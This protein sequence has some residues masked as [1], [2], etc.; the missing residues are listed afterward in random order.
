MLRISTMVSALV[1]LIV[2]LNCD[3]FA[4]EA[5]KPKKPGLAQSLT[6]LQSNDT[7]RHAAATRALVEHGRN[8]HKL[9]SP[10]RKSK[11]PALAKRA[12][13]VCQ[14]IEMRAKQ[15][16]IM[17]RKLNFNLTRANLSVENLQKVQQAFREM[18][19]YTPYPGLRNNAETYIR[20]LDQ[21][22]KVVRAATDA[23]AK[24]DSRMG[25]KPAPTGVALADLQCQ[26]AQKLLELKRYSQALAATEAGINVE[27]K[28]NRVLPVLLRVRA[29][30]QKQTRDRKG[31]E[32]TCK[33]ILKECPDSIE[34]RDAH[35]LLIQL[36]QSLERKDEMFEQLKAYA[37]DF[38]R[39][40][41]AQ[42]TLLDH[43]Q[44]LFEIDPDYSG[45]AR[46]SAFMVDALPPSRIDKEVVRVF[47]QTNEYVVKDYKKAEKGYRMLMELY[48]DQ[49]SEEALKAALDRIKK[50]AAG[51]FPKGPD[52][53]DPGPAGVFARFIVALSKQDLDALE[54]LTLEDD[55]DFLDLRI[56]EVMMEVVLSDYV[57]DKVETDEKAGKAILHVRHFIPKQ[58]TPVPEK[59][60]I[61]KEAD[62]WRVHWP[63]PDFED[64]E[65]DTPQAD[66]FV[67]PTQMPRTKPDAPK[68]E[69]G[70]S[71]GASTEKTKKPEP[72]AA[73]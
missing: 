13:L 26:R 8:A 49:I 63:D 40:K 64:E 29:L 7:K 48:P 39:D 70:K 14:R 54:E 3:C 60:K 52:A 58:A 6:D 55:F 33:R 21:K 73:K 67:A 11:D 61:M 17:A 32:V 59:I 56:E 38:P 50:K 68:P 43:L 72:K 66:G 9:V 5:P 28:T 41:K 4:A 1:C 12:R 30:A 25:A 36:F 34:V 53:K 46:L 71:G 27:C 18:A 23:L 44:V 35:I 24:L 19:R 45:A 42:D 16:I 2:S 10:L 51:E 15:Q 57:V 22:I 47:A 65:D 62:A 37:R 69:P 20:Q 31:L